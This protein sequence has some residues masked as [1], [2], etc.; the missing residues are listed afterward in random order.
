[1]RAPALVTDIR[2]GARP[3]GRC[4]SR[5]EALLAGQVRGAVTGP[6][7]PGVGG[8]EHPGADRQA[9]AA[10]AQRVAG[11]VEAL[12]VGADAGGQDALGAVRM[13][14]DRLG[15]RSDP[16]R[17]ERRPPARARARAGHPRTQ[18]WSRAPSPRP[19]PGQNHKTRRTATR[20]WQTDPIP[21]QAEDQHTRPRSYAQ[22]SHVA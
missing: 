15:E 16:A 17:A 1:M 8:G 9:L 12:V 10:G 19:P 7:G 22:L 6:L 13:Q 20:P 3:E 14:A 4:A 2:P 11:A 5:V 18:Y 21:G